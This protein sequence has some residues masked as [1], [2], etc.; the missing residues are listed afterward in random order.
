MSD[1]LPLVQKY[2]GPI[3]APKHLNYYSA[4]GLDELTEDRGAIAL[5]VEGAIEKLK[6]SDR[7][8]DP[9]GFEEVVKIVRHARVTLLDGEKKS[10]YDLQLKALLRKVAPD[11]LG[12][13][14]QLLTESARLKELLPS[15]DP[16]APF[17]LADF[18]KSR[19][20]DIAY[21]T[22]AERQA[23]LRPLLENN[24]TEMAGAVNKP[25]Q[26]S[27]SGN[28]N[29]AIP[30]RT[31]A[32]SSAS[33]RSRSAKAL[34]EELRRNRKQKNL[35]TFAISIGAACLLV[36]VGLWMFLSSEAE[37]QALATQRNTNQSNVN[38]N[39][40]VVSTSA[41]DNANSPNAAAGN[42]EKKPTERKRMNL[43]IVSNS[44]S[45]AAESASPMRLPTIGNEAPS[46]EPAGD[47]APTMSETPVEPV[48]PPMT[49]PVVNPMDM[50][51]PTTPA[52]TPT[53]TPTPTTDNAGAVAWADAMTAA[54]QA[55]KQRK[56]DLFK[57][58][59]EKAFAATDDPEKVKQANSLDLIGQ[60]IPMSEQAFRDGYAGLRSSNTIILG[61]SNKAS[62]VEA[63]PDLLVARVKGQNQRIPVDQLPME[64]V[65]AIADLKLTDTPVDDAVRGTI[66]Q[67]DPRATSE[68]KVDAKKFYSKAA[69]K[70]T[71][72]ADLEKVFEAVYK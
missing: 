31:S 15:G 27:G 49:E 43:G 36:G 52:L 17:S 6:R 23:A 59:L 9:K 12:E 67:W 28:A 10:T 61:G 63:K 54:L 53:P 18:L 44:K 32:V 70:A 47:A 30:S 19:Q 5:A 1:L 4:L 38:Q 16:S 45:P 7:T 68:S 69:S 14:S 29:Q 37:Q 8:E 57:I 24:Q 60:L 62:I 26:N 42:K 50:T 25:A 66:L 34:Q 21:E 58:E 46:T 2:I 51:D 13:G 3:A 39:T 41:E 33:E 22:I 20:E 71:K 55:I 40:T 56:L 35:I 65:L 64:W 48:V 72:F 11:V